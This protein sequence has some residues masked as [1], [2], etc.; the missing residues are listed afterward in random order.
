[1]RWR[2]RSRTVML[3]PLGS[4]FKNRRVLP[5]LQP[6]TDLELTPVV[7]ASISMQACG[8]WGTR[9]S[10]QNNHRK[11]ER[12][13]GC[14]ALL[15]AMALRLGV[16]EADDARCLATDGGLGRLGPALPLRPADN[17]LC[18]GKRHHGGG[19]GGGC[20]GLHGGRRGSKRGCLGSPQLSAL[21]T[22]GP[23]GGWWRRPAQ[24]YQGRRGDSG[25]CRS[26]PPGRIGT[27]S[28]ALHISPRAGPHAQH[29][30]Y[31]R[32]IRT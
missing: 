16:A 3:W 13:G 4:A 31:G 29:T 22:V 32:W 1:M 27:I 6:T 26:R 30:V 21:P 8:R 19:R 9:L 11:G 7:R 28:Q 24:C 25:Q 18:V 10:G 5:N 12:T 14:M 17:E 20:G 15:R 23:G 2:T